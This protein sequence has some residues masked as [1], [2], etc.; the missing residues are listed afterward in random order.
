MNNN[1]GNKFK[2]KLYDMEGTPSLRVWDGIE[3]NLARKRT[4]RNWIYFGLS[5]IVISFIGYFGFYNKGTVTIAQVNNHQVINQNQIAETNVI[6]PNNQTPK[7]TVPEVVT[8]NVET[9]NSTPQPA[10]V[11]PQ[12]VASSK[13]NKITL[14]NEIMTN[15][16]LNEALK[17]KEQEPANDD[18]RPL[19]KIQIV[20]DVVPM[21]I[22][23]MFRNLVM[24]F[25]NADIENNVRENIYQ[26]AGFHMGVAADLNNTYILKQ[27]TY[28][29]FSGKN[30]ATKLTYGGAYS[31]DVGYDFNSRYGVQVEGVLNA[32]KGQKFADVYNGMPVSRD[33]SLKYDEVPVFFKYK[34]SNMSTLTGR[35]SV[36][37][38]IGGLEYGYLLSANENLMGT[39]TDITNRFNHNDI[40]MLAGLEWDVYFGHHF[41]FDLGVRGSYSLLDINAPGWKLEPGTGSTR[42][43]IFGGN[44]GI[45]YLIN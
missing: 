34:M 30:L 25:R 14:V 12:T 38:F 40:S 42:N 23:P 41:F 18:L 45:N 9:I 22:D 33:I 44:F 24:T 19:L 2:D 4:S 20:S 43:M 3:K 6:Q 32:S 8:N 28:N 17:V 5:I 7:V 36:V 35:P 11:I 26:I 39:V 21:H 27:N 15:A 29:E 13:E 37:N 10:K 1:M 31:F 16:L